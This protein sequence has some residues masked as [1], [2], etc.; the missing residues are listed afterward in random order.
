M[1][2][3]G[4]EY[5]ITNS[6]AP[7][8][9]KTGCKTGSPQYEMPCLWIKDKTCD[10]RSTLQSKRENDCYT[11]R[12]P[13]L[14]CVNCSKYLL[15]DSVIERVEQMLDKVNSAAELEIIQYAA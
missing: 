14:Q 5:L 11:Q 10:H 13:V 2:R 12:L 15:E 1:T 3:G 4:N 7:R 9:G 8:F 6:L